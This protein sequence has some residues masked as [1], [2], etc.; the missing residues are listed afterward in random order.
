MTID[1]DRSTAELVDAISIALVEECTAICESL[2]AKG[3]L[4]DGERDAAEEL[5]VERIGARMRGI[6][7]ERQRMLA[8]VT[9]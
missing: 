1:I 6:E 3:L 5:L 4:V 7:L 2:D 9:H 8:E